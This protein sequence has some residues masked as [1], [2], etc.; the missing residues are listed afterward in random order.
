MNG[1]RRPGE[2][3]ALP[4]TPA[5]LARDVARVVSAGAGAVHLHVKDAQGGDTMGS[6]E[7]A[8][9][10]AAVRQAA[11]AVPIGV[12]TGAWMEPDPGERLT[13]ILAWEALPNFASVNWHEEGANDIAGALLEL[14]VDVEAGLW[15]ADAVDAWLA[16]PLRDRCYRVLL[17]LPDGLDADGTEAEADALLHL[18]DA[19]VGDLRRVLLHGKGTSCWPAL[20]HAAH[21]GLSIRIGLEDV[22]ELPDGSAA[23]DNAALVYAARALLPPP[24]PGREVGTAQG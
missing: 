13:A 4:V 10:L 8:A 19:G 3:P 20:R 14:G 2:H 1:A 16:S 7:L 5:E 17:E 18:V 9:V 22:L 11:P 12:S 23:A 24:E 21:R 15:R 6:A